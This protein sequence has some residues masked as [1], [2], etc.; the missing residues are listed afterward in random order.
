VRR[1]KLAARFESILM[2]GQAATR[3]GPDRPFGF[4]TVLALW[5]IKC[6]VLWVDRIVIRILYG[7]G[8]V[9]EIVGVIWSR[10]LNR[11]KGLGIVATRTA[12]VLRVLV[13]RA[14]FEVRACN[15]Y[16]KIV[17]GS[18]GRGERP[19]KGRQSR[20]RCAAEA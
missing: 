13:R 15:S 10:S 14:I 8:V 5:E 16:R 17:R 4:P 20:Y 7:T 3:Q 12:V 11:L 18:S 6:S 19:R 9:S 1:I 2:A